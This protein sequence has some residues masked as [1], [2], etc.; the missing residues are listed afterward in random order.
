MTDTRQESDSLGTIEVP[1]D[2]L[3]GAQTQRCLMN[4]PIGT[5]MMPVPFVRALGLQK[6]AAALANKDLG[7]L[8]AKL[9]DA[10][11]VAAGEVAEGKHDAEFPLPVWQTGSG[12]QSNMNANEVIANRASEMLGGTRGSKEPVHP[13]D[14]VNMGQSSND[15][16]PTVM[17]VSAVQELEGKLLPALDGMIKSIARFRE[18]FGGVIKLGRTHFQDATPITLGQAFSAYQAQVDAATGALKQQLPRLSQLPQG[19][20]AVGTGLN[21]HPDFASGFCD[22]LSSLTGLP[23]SPA[24]NKFVGIS[25]H[26]E[27]VALSGVLNGAAAALMKIAGDIR[28]MGSGP[29]GGLAELI[30]PKN[31]PGSSI[32][33]GKVNPTQVEA[34]TMV[35]AQIMGN[36]T[37]VTIAGS[38]GQLELNAYK[39]VIIFNVLQSIRLLAD[40]TDSFTAR[41]LDGLKPDPDRIDTL[42]K[43]SL[44]LA[45]SLVPHIGYDKTAEIARL[46][47]DEKLLLKEAAL[48][49]G[50]VTEEDFDRWT[51]PSQ[52]THPADS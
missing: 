8:D 49:L 22:H 42:L 16:I 47:N 21:C 44:M 6:K 51:D 4:F 5:D 41:C 52:M 26:D 18:K 15:T 34:L 37:T 1:T 40:A 36:H 23:F 24:A 7:L 11:A 19:G 28:L 12:T 13:N 30:L 35:C 38:Q 32:M 33:A 20:T 14:H 50:Y 48:K 9:A 25:A 2:R 46:A 29:R 31:E 27:L 3:W 43:S 45:T 10:I 17:L 39:P